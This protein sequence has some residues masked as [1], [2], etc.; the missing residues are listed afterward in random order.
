MAFICCKFVQGWIFQTG[1]RE[2]LRWP[3]SCNGSFTHIIGPINP[4]TRQPVT[5]RKWFG[6]DQVW[7]D[8]AWLS[9]SP[10][11]LCQLTWTLVHAGWLV[12]DAHL[13]EARMW[14]MWFNEW[15]AVDARFGAPIA[16]FVDL[17]MTLLRPMFLMGQGYSVKNFS[18]R[19]SL[20]SST[21]SSVEFSW[22][23]QL[24]SWLYNMFIELCFNLPLRVYR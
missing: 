19:A 10:W 24:S 13:W 23:C 2:T 4:L 16:V 12:P 3:I 1:N 21:P 20:W 17:P 8:G 18:A 6:G 9:F 7:W 5:D 22:W 11:C 15:W 14:Q